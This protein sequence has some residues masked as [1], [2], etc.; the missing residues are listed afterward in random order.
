MGICGNSVSSNSI[1]RTSI[2]TQ[3]RFQPAAEAANNQADQL[4]YEACR[5]DCRDANCFAREMTE[6]ELR[7]LFR[8][9]EQMT[10]AQRHQFDLELAKESGRLI[11]ENARKNQLTL[12]QLVWF[13]EEANKR[14]AVGADIINDALDQACEIIT[15]TGTDEQKAV[16]VEWC[17]LEKKFPPGHPGRSVD[18]DAE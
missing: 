8:R 4:Y 14:N 2:L 5:L 12:D 17:L 10:P 6:E 16:I 1:A 15:E 3:P 13:F 11:L 9:L 7:A 18:P